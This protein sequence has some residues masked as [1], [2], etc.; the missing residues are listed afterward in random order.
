M[1]A[2][3]VFLGLIG[4]TLGCTLARVALHAL[5]NYRAPYAFPIAVAV[6]P[7]VTVYGFALLLSVAAGVLCGILPA[8]EAR[9]T[10]LGEVMKTGAIGVPGHIRRWTVRD[11]LL[12]IEV[13]LC[14]VLV[15]A[16]AV[17]LRG[18]LQS[19]HVHLGF[20]PNGVT[21]VSYNLDVA[22]YKRDAAFQFNRKLAEQAALVPGVQSV[23]F[24]DNTPLDIVGNNSNEV[25]RAEITDLRPAN[26]SFWAQTFNISPNYLQTAR[27]A[28]RE[29]R[30]FTWT[31]DAMA[32]R[33]AIM[34]EQ[35]ANSLFG[36]QFAL[37]KAFKNGNG[38]LVRIVGLVEQGKY[39]SLNEDP[40]PVIFYPIA[41]G[42]GMLTKL[43]V[44]L[45]PAAVDDA[46]R[47]ANALTAL[48][49]AQ[50]PA[51]PISSVESWQAALS[52]VLFPARAATVA[53][54]VLGGLALVL[55]VTGIF[56]L[57]SYTVARR[58]REF[59]IRVALGATRNAV[60]RAALGRVGRLVLAGS[61]LGLLAGLAS[62]RLLAAIVYGARAS[63]PWVLLSVAITMIC[64]GCGA[65][66]VPARRALRVQPVILLREE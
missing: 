42:A 6:E 36:H 54:G 8:R 22:G 49:H 27:I 64:V 62:T 60:L 13:A 16:S 35:F 31:D 59:G 19:R 51:V 26:R 43:L 34:N 17:S 50:D 4:G 28:L 61:F 11:A 10:E 5:T 15:T 48:L 58:M 37:G 1:L 57:A 56:G 39:G 20:D 23:A 30:D 40:V 55:A 46:P 32:P 41:Q 12:L 14:C 47:V 21:L 2:E 53:L 7:R 65:T 52:P 24:G 25:Y 18:L 66:V 63:D 45:S 38:K 44:R 3:S 33:V 29:G 9:R